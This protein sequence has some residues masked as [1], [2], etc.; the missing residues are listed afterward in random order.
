MLYNYSFLQV[1]PKRDAAAAAS[2]NTQT[3]TPAST[4]KQVRN[5][6]VY[7]KG[8]ISF[9]PFGVPKKYTLEGHAFVFEKYAKKNKIHV[10]IYDVSSPNT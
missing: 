7:T 2:I 4:V 8:N 6:L 3:S 5:A 1:R 10:D 9:I